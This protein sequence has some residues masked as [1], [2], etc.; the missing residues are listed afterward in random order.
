MQCLFPNVVERRFVAAPQFLHGVLGS[1]SLT[2]LVLT[3]GLGILE[4]STCLAS[5]S[6]WHRMENGPKA[7]NGKVG[8]KIENGS[9]PEVGF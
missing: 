1:L 9:R 8:R 3:V 7:E 6:A 2:H 5:Q 4:S